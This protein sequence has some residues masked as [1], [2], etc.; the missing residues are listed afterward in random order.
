LLG[1]HKAFE[2]EAPFNNDFASNEDI[3]NFCDEKDNLQSGIVL[4]LEFNLEGLAM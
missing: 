2:S 4:C 3:K 1:K